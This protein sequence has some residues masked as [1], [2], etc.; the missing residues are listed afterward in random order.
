MNELQDSG[1]EGTMRTELKRGK[2]RRRRHDEKRSSKRESKAR[3]I[4]RARCD[5][6]VERKAS[7]MAGVRDAKRADGGTERRPRNGTAYKWEHSREEQR[8]QRRGEKRQR[9][10]GSAEQ[11]AGQSVR[12]GSRREERWRRQDM[13]H[14]C[15]GGGSGDEKGVREERG[16]R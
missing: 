16:G 12:R 6:G 2:R 5:I 11:G 10:E 8:E 9:E 1:T 15:K 7:R 13:T 14:P 4:Q 3:F